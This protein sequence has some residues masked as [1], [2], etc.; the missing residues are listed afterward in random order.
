M[1]MPTEVLVAA[2]ALVPQVATVVVS[3]VLVELAN[4]FH[5]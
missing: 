1:V 4:T 5:C 3:V 2:A